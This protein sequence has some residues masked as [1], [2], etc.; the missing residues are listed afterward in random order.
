MKLRVELVE[1]EGVMKQRIRSFQL[2]TQG[3]K[4]T[5]NRCDFVNVRKGQEIPPAFQ[6]D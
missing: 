5:R 2:E 1:F 6:Q 4:S 3:Q